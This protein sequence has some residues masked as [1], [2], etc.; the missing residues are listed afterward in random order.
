MKGIG[1]LCIISLYSFVSQ[2][3]TSTSTDPIRVSPVVS[4]SSYQY[5]RYLETKEGRFLTDEITSFE[6]HSANGAMTIHWQ[7]GREDGLKLFQ[8]EYSTDDGNT[9][10]AAGTVLATNIDH[11]GSYIFRHET[12]NTD[13]K[14]GRLFYRLMLVDSYGNWTYS[15]VIQASTMAR[16]GNF[17]YPT[18]V[19]SHLVY[20]YLNDAYN[21]VEV[22]DMSGRLLSKQVIS[23]RTG[24]I[25]V[26]IPAA[27]SGTCIIRVE[28]VNNSIVQKVLVDH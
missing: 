14:T 2:A 20:L 8:I 15:K 11:G 26:P 24:R 18:F 16:A 3:Q 9:F 12:V 27:A 28:G 19:T 17:I 21:T 7:T 1:L 10:Q 23:G 5:G 25:D 22:L 4:T 6:A 13:T